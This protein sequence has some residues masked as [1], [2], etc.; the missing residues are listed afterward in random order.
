[1]LHVHISEYAPGCGFIDPAR[2]RGPLA[3]P[4]NTEWPSIGPL[5]AW[6]AGPRAFVPLNVEQA[7]SDLPDPARPI[8]LDALSGTVDLRAN[9]TDMPKVRMQHNPQL[10]L[11]PAAIRAYLAPAKNARRHLVMRTIFDGSK[12]LPTGSP[13][14]HILGVRHLPPER[15]LLRHGRHVRHADGVARRRAER[16]QH[17]GRAATAP[18]STASRRSRSPASTVAAARSSRSRTSSGPPGTQ[19]TL[20]E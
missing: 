18:T 12:L 2:P 6:A 7:P 4:Y 19:I 16:V 5:T 17:E 1:M 11:A 20:I 14:W 9:V 3:D 8:A 13:L 10:A 15:L